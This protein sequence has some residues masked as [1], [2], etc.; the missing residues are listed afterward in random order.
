MYCKLK[1]YF[2]ILCIALFS[3]KAISQNDNLPNNKKQFLKDSIA[4]KF[5]KDS[6]HLYRFLKVRPYLDLDNRNTIIRDF[7]VNVR[8]FLAGLVLFEKHAVG[9]GYY[10]INHKSSD[11]NIKTVINNEEAFV[12]TRINYFTL[13]YYYILV[14]KKYFQINIPL[15]GGFGNYDI[16]AFSKSTKEELQQNKGKL[17]LVGSGLTLVLRPIK[18]IGLSSKIGYRLVSDETSNLNFNGL[19]YSLGVWLNIKQLYRDT[20]F[21]GFMRPKYKKRVKRIENLKID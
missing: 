20:R 4:K 15:E 19:Y 7:R 8:G 5:K 17:L 13:F 1:N 6:L 9:V 18:H 10:S 2:L 14:D 12:T 21:Y 3:L 16:N 11:R